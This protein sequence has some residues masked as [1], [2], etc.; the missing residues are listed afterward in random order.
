MIK[1]RQGHIGFDLRRDLLSG[2]GNYH[3]LPKP[4]SRGALEPVPFSQ[5]ASISG[6]SGCIESSCFPAVDGR[7]T[8]KLNELIE[9][10][11][12]PNR[13]S[14]FWYSK[15]SATTAAEAHLDRM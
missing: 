1:Q 7:A 2:S 8:H 10:S 13:S 6:F 4:T 15:R 3:I 11:A 14:S 12:G 9:G 5:L